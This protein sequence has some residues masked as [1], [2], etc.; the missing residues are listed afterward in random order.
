MKRQLRASYAK[1][2]LGRGKTPKSVEFVGSI[3]QT[4]AGKTDEK[5]LH[6]NTGMVPGVWYTGAQ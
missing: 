2:R 5:E 4:S 3:P 6:K 1:Q